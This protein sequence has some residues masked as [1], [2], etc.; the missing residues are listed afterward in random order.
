VNRWT[1]DLLPAAQK[2]LARLENGPL[3]EAVSILED[4][5]ENGPEFI[6][7][8]ELR[9]NPATWRAR[10]HHDRFRML[11][12]VSRTKKRIVVIRIRPR[13]SAYEGLKH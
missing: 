10:I 3:Q 13:P 6:P 7:A 12:Q 4:M 1:V 9:A 2:E 8:I 5:R 11:Y